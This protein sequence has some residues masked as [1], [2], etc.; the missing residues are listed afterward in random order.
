D[1]DLRSF[2]NLVR[3]APDDR[4]AVLQ[5]T[6]HLDEIADT[7]TATHVDPLRHSV[8]DA[9]HKD[10]FRRGDNAGWRHEQR[11]L[12]TPNG[13]LHLGIHTRTEPQVRILHVQLRRHASRLLI[14]IMGQQVQNAVERLAWISRY[15]E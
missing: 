9:N 12:R 2:T 6:E 15:R 4:V 7:R 11:W 14:Q 1:V 8:A 10:A 3:A 5:R 13:P